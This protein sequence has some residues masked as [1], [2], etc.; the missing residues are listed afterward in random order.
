NV[1]IGTTSPEHK[2]HVTGTESG[3]ASAGHAVGYFKN[4]YDGTASNPAAVYGE[5][6]NT[7][8]YG[9]GGY[10]KGGWQGVAGAV[11]ATSD[12]DYY[13]VTGYVDGGSGTNYGVL[14]HAYGGTTNYGVYGYANGGTDYG[15]YCNGDGAYTGS[16]TDVSD[17]K[18]KKNIRP[19][20]GILEKVLLLQPKTFEMRTQGYDFMG[21]SDGAEYGLIAQELEEVF[22]ELVK[23]GVHP[24]D[25]KN[26]APVEYKGIDYI[27]LTAILIEAMQEQQAQIEQLRAEKDAE[28][29]ELRARIEAL[30]SK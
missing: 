26:H 27:P 21:F 24:G 22:P 10:F 14:G 6:A 11:Y 8:N 4:L 30:E 3:S 28:I 18:F 5:C 2:L 9:I 23:H 29:A 20:E 25:E 19:M 16:W 13:G 12:R 1:G 17:R 7:D 15:V